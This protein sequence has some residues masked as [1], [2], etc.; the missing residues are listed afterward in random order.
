MIAPLQV[1]NLSSSSAVVFALVATSSPPPVIAR[2]SLT[3]RIG[4]EIP[5]PIT[6][7]HR[8]VK[9]TPADPA[10][11]AH[12]LQAPTPERLS[13]PTTPAPHRRGD[14]PRVL[15]NVGEYSRSG[16]S[17]LSKIEEIGLSHWIAPTINAAV[18]ARQTTARAR[19]IAAREKR[20]L[21]P[22][23]PPPVDGDGHRRPR[24]TPG[25]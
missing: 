1:H 11:P 25:P 19:N 16:I 2:V 12:D 7:A 8:L 6:P 21:T 13:A 14:A 10:R 3:G 18:A 5:S 22:P 20:R 4:G 24:T 17:A 23:P 15:V 9:A